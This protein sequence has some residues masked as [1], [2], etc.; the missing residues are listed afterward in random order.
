MTIWQ[1]QNNLAS[2][3]SA[4]MEKLTTQKRAAI[5]RCLI[6]GNSILATSRITGAVK[7]TIINLLEQAGEACAAYQSEH[8]RKL[9]CSAS[10]GRDLVFCWMP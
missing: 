8:F 9:P 5:L 10:I 6:E 4:T 3:E 7:G 1:G 2:I